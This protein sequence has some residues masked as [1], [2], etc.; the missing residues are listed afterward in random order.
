MV[1]WSWGAKMVGMARLVWA[2]LWTAVLGAQ[3][4]SPPGAWV[5]SRGIRVHVPQGWS[6]NDR[7]V[8]A[9]GPVSMNNFGGVYVS[10][11]VLPADGAEIEITRVPAPPDVT[12]YIQNEL[13]GTNFEALRES[14]GGIRTTYQETLYPGASLKTV[15]AYVP[16]GAWLYKF[17]LTY[18]SGEGGAPAFTAAFEKVMQEAQLR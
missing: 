3:T 11:G 16:R 10:G 15:V 7:L 14:G 1:V 9:A 17:F 6:Y 8:K 4:A 12:G 18:W 13:K 5:E 2:F